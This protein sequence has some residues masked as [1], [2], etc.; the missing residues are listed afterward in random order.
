MTNKEIVERIYHEHPIKKHILK[1][2]S[3]SFIDKSCD[4]LEQYIYIKLLEMNN[5]ELNRLY[6]NGDYKKYI[7]QIIK[8][9]RDSEMK[10]ISKKSGNLIKYKTSEYTKIFQLRDYE[11]IVDYPNQEDDTIYDPRVEFIFGCLS[12][13]SYYR[14]VSGSSVQQLR[15]AI[16]SD[17]LL[18]YIRRKISIRE[19]GEKFN[20]KRWKVTMLLKLVK[21]ELLDKFEKEYCENDWINGIY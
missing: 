3:N 7:T 21:D 12:G 11:P 18:F 5:K 14:S 1:N 2:I 10:Y 15:L 9:S 6:S 4:D 19:V 17:L 13:Y 8:N 16:A 20:M